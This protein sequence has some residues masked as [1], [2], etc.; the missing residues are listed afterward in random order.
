MLLA[1]LIFQYSEIDIE[2]T[3]TLNIPLVYDINV[4]V[5]MKLY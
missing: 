2:L 5:S 4:K 1:K 3:K